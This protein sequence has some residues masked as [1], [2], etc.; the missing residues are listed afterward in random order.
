MR[1]MSDPLQIRYRLGKPIEIEAQGIYVEAPCPGGGHKFYTGTSF[2]LPACH[3]DR[4][5]AA[6]RLSGPA[7]L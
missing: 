3:G 1:P 2:R 4:G 5:A 6:F 7:A